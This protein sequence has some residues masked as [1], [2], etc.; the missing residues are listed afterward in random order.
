MLKKSF[1]FLLILLLW[2]A[3]VWSVALSDIIAGIVVS[4]LIVWL[5][6]DIFP[7][8]LTK[9]M[10]PVRILWGLLYVPVFLWHVI[11]SNLDVA[12]RVFHPE[13]PIRPGIVKVKT[14]LNNEL[15]KTFLAN[16]ITLTP[17]TLTV[18]FVDDNI[19]VHWINIISDDPE[20]ETRL[21]VSKFE[22][23]LKKIFE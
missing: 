22:K 16:S 10:N 4:L 3:L 15:A 7:A 2:I 1:E 17:G 13:I 9:L 23:Y 20:V 21:I 5:F 14:N 11:K 12:Y 8:E 6:S 19:Y 18:D